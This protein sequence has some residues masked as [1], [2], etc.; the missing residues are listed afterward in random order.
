MHNINGGRYAGHVAIDDV[1]RITCRAS[2]PPTAVR[3]ATMLIVS[4][5]CRKRAMPAYTLRPHLTALTMDVKL[6][7]ISKMSDASFAI[8]VPVKKGRE[9]QAGRVKGNAKRTRVIYNSLHV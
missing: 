6:L 5:N 4:W 2:A 8:D 9:C 1:A 7:S 3:M